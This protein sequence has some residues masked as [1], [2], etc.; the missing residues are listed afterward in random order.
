MSHE[1]RFVTTDDGERIAITH[2]TAGHPHVIIVCHGFFQRR[3][4]RLFRA[5]AQ[6]LTPHSDV[7]SMDFRGHGQS[8]GR[9]TFSARETLDVLA[10]LH[11]VRPRYQRVCGL[12][13]SLGTVSVLDAAVRERTMDRLVLVSPPMAFEEIENHWWAPRS[14]ITTLRKGSWGWTWRLGSLRLPKPRPL[15]LI[16]R[17][18]PTPVLLIHG[19]HDPIV[20]ARH[21]V[22][23]YAAAAEPKRC[24]M[25]P[26]GLHAE[27]LFADDPD[28]FVRL[29]SA[30]CFA[31]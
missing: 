15:E 25:I 26:R 21:S 6:R 28:G 22:A 11:D 29:V 30:W 19:T 20:T 9:Y 7:V 24:A 2:Y 16:A 8:S 1:D 23:L 5:L 14:L 4:T 27:A 31:E 3:R 18:A 12:G 17:V 10:V 13:F